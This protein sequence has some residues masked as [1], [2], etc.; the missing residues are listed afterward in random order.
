MSSNKSLNKNSNKRSNKNSNKS[1]N[2][3]T[4]NSIYLKKTSHNIFNKKSFVK[5]FKVKDGKHQG[6]FAKITIKNDKNGEKQ[7]SVKYDNTRN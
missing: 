6:K 5:V 4:Y 2:K 1:S 3:N 7:Y